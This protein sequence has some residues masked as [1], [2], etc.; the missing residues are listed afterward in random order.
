LTTYLSRNTVVFVI[1]WYGLSGLF[2]C[3]EWRADSGEFYRCPGK[4]DMNLNTRVQHLAERWG[5]NLFGVADLSP[6]HDAILEQGGP[7]V[8]EYPYA[9]SIGI[10]LPHSVVNQLSQRATCAVALSYGHFAYATEQYLD[11]MSLQVSGFLQREG[12]RTIPIPAAQQVDDKRICAAFSHKLAAHLAGLGWIG[13]NCLLVTPDVGP[14]VCWTT[15]LTDAPLAITGKPM[16]E[17]C[18][19]CVKC[20]S[21]CPVNAF[22]GRVFK[23]DEPREARFDANKCVRYFEKMEEEDGRAVCSLCLYICPYGN[24]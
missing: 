2:A 11:V 9:V 20:V 21:I 15:V 1:T 17:R 4:R 3:G 5:A 24:S 19:E 8:A 23:E 22:T 6:A 16:N 7:V 13:K 12:Y 14:R 18:A 10:I